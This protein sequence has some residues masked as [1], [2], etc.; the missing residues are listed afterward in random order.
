VCPEDGDTDGK[1][2]LYFAGEAFS[3][4]YPGYLQ[5]AYNSA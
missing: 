2:T 4:E 5:G 3:D 1:P